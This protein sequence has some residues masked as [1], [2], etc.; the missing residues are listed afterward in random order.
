MVKNSTRKKI[1]ASTAAKALVV[2]DIA[3]VSYVPLMALVL[4]V[5][6]G[7]V[8]FLGQDTPE[9]SLALAGT[10]SASIRDSSESKLK[11]DQRP[12]KR[13]QGLKQHP[14]FK[15]SW[16]IFQRIEAEQTGRV[17]PPRSLETSPPQR[18]VHFMQF[19][20]GVSQL[21]A[22][23]GSWLQK[24]NDFMSMKLDAMKEWEDAAIFAY[25][26]APNNNRA[27]MLHMPLDM[28]DFRYVLASAF[29][30]E[31]LICL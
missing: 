12:L 14:Q 30:L 11:S 8:F 16:D 31:S 13:K 18:P 15:E 23:S 25:H 22:Y 28:L 3:K 21:E 10:S 7:I 9:L 17:V 1:I 5:V 27:S 19:H 4:V 29:Q 24:K 2:S 6:S 26:D 20:T